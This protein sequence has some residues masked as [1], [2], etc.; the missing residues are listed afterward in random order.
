M[1]Y[2][3]LNR[4]AWDVRVDQH[5]DSDFYDV[6]GWLAGKT[7]LKG[8]ELELLGDLTGL[9]VLHLMC[10]FGQ[11]TLSLKRAGAA[12]VVGLDLSPRAIEEARRL[13]ARAGLEATFVEGDF[14][15]APELIAGPFD[16]LFMSYG[17]IGWLPDI[18]RWGEVVAGFLRP[19][20]RFVFAEFHPA[21]WMLDEEQARVKYRYFGGEPI[22]ETEGTY[23][24]V[25][26]E[27]PQQMMSWNHG[28]GEVVGALMA[29][30]L[31]LKHF[32]EYD[33]SP[34]AIFGERGVEMAPG[35]WGVAGSERMLPLVYSLVMQKSP[36]RT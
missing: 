27:R 18:A 29:R 22:V 23:T 26:E 12:G 14:Y 6:E 11:D 24:D 13:A 10:H 3:E 15:R 5:V 28:L 17:T 31:S 25:A 16:V 21:L 32:A 19:G 35:E 7:S 8:I 4:A 33:Y 34:Y 1:D 36:P 30:G 20:G 9:R 2:L